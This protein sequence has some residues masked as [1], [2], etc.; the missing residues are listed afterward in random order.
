MS[1]VTK[2]E[3]F[4]LVAKANGQTTRTRAAKISDAI[5]VAF[6]A[7]N[8]NIDA[9]EA[10]RSYLLVATGQVWD[11]DYR[12][13]NYLPKH[14]PLSE[15]SILNLDETLMW[16]AADPALEEPSLVFLA[17]SNKPESIEAKARLHDLCSQGLI[18][19]ATYEGFLYVELED[20]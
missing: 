11:P 10:V 4:D 15:T 6:K 5:G 16:I 9:R 17:A 18:G 3:I 1:Y 7:M 2:Q 20:V 14:H 19:R 13:K 8:D 12:Y